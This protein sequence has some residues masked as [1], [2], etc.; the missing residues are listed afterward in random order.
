MKQTG[1]GE[2]AMYPPAVSP[3]DYDTFG[4]AT[5][6]ITGFCDMDTDIHKLA[7][8]IEGRVRKVIKRTIRT[9]TLEFK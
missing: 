2:I 6:R 7:G 4:Y 5:F 9:E 8:N 3:G 1:D